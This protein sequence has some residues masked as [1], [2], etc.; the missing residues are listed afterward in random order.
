MRYSKILEF[1][2]SRGIHTVDLGLERVERLLRKL[3]NPQNK[4]DV[5]LVAGTNGKGSTSAMISSILQESN[6][7]VG[8]YSSPH[9]LR[10]TERFKINEQEIEK[11]NVESIFEKIK[12]H[13]NDNDGLTYF[14]IITVMAYLYFAEQKVDYAIM[15]VGMGGRLDATNVVDPLVSVI[16]N[17]S[18]EHTEY[19]GKTVEDIAYEKAGIIKENGHVITGVSEGDILDVL[20]QVAMQK[21]ATLLVA[22][23]TGLE[24]GLKGEF[25]KINAGIA[26]K[27]I[28]TLKYFGVEIPKIALMN[29]LARAQLA[30][31]FEFIKR[32][33][34]VDC[35]HNV[36]AVEALVEEISR[37]KEELVNP[38]YKEDDEYKELRFNKLHLVFGVMKDKDVKDMISLLEPLFDTITLT[39]P[40]GEKEEM[41]E[42]SEDPKIISKY[43]STHSKVKVIENPMQ[44]LKK[45]NS[46]AKQDDLI[47]VTGSCYLVGDVM[48]G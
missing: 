3:G 39:R 42:R 24:L 44:A 30:G 19:L 10:F 36:A 35:A 8:V 2:Y 45:A 7:K 16:T 25:Q 23:P 33:L 20:R 11:K 12:P 48:R 17:I 40:L 47:V 21:Q 14:E 5:I 43:I 15:E 27:T 31:R 37:L 32:N 29:G 6:F 4:V 9:L 28:K 41:K 13:L 38:N 34:L 1:L 18:L 26:I 22:T 46:L